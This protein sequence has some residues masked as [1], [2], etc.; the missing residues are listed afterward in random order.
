MGLSDVSDDDR[1]QP[2]VHPF[3]WLVDASRPRSGLIQGVGFSAALRMPRDRVEGGSISRSILDRGTPPL[4][5]ISSESPTHPQE[6]TLP[7]SPHTLH[8]STPQPTTQISE[9]AA[10]VA[11]AMATLG[12]GGGI[13]R[14]RDDEGGKGDGSNKRPKLVEVIS[15]VDSSDE[16]EAGAADVKPASAAATAAGKGGG[17]SS[18]GA[19]ASLAA[20]ASSWQGQG[21]RVGPAT[22]NPNGGLAGGGGRSEL[23]VL[24]FY[25]GRVCIACTRGA[26]DCLA[27]CACMYASPTHVLISNT[28]WSASRSSTTRTPCRSATCSRGT[29]TR[30]C[31]CVHA[32][33]RQCVY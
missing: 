7:N 12:G 14:G 22:G 32:C 4:A 17:S 9:E 2:A 16:D 6:G 28:R 25:L 1:Q 30:P 8:P 23:P 13:G 5:H 19:A 27:V 31:W 20:A 26:Y 29:T 18:S 33:V 10:A 21:A 11:A 24:P 15:L 3:G